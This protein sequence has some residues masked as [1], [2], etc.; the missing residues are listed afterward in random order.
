VKLIIE[1]DGK[2]FSFE[3]ISQFLFRAVRTENELSQEDVYIVSINEANCR[4]CRV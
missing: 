1:V 3:E 2:E 4:I